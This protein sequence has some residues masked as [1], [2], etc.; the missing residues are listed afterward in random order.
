MPADT[1]RQIGDGRA[2]TGR[3]ALT[4][5]LVDQIG[6][7]HDARVWL[8]SAKN[9]S[10]D[11]P[12]EDVSTTSLASRTFGGSLGPMFDGIW[13]VLVS[14]SVRIDGALAIWQPGSN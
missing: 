4:L 13:K 11:L 14:Q 8:A 12:V 3:Q 6:E 2:C 1:V 5:G 7:E 10:A 9:V